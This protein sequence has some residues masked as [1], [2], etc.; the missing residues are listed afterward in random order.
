[1][2]KQRSQSEKQSGGKST[3]QKARDDRLKQALRANLQRRKA[4]GRARDVDKPD[5]DNRGEGQ[6]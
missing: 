1:M 2:D 6:N 3:P 4:Q 5:D